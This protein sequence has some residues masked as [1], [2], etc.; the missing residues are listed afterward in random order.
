M[1][2][3]KDNLRN[4][5]TFQVTLSQQVVILYKTQLAFSGIVDIFGFP[6]FR[7]F[8]QDRCVNNVFRMQDVLFIIVLMLLPCLYEYTH[9]ERT[10]YYIFG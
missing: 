9:L 8:F 1:G 7:F 10:T 3:G 2:R 5:H 4:F 6:L